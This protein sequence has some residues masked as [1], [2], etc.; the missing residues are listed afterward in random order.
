[1]Q[2][3]CRNRT[4]GPRRGRRINQQ[5]ERPAAGG[6]HG[7]RGHLA[8]DAGAAV[9]DQQSGGKEDERKIDDHGRAIAN[10]TTTRNAPH[11]R[12]RLQAGIAGGRSRGRDGQPIRQPMTSRARRSGSRSRIRQAAR[13]SRAAVITDTSNAGQPP[14][15]VAIPSRLADTVPLGTSRTV[16]AAGSTIGFMASMGKAA[17]TRSDNQVLATVISGSLPVDRLRARAAWAASNGA[18]RRKPAGRPRASTAN[19]IATRAPLPNN[20]TAVG[21]SGSRPPISASSRRRR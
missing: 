10:A 17:M 7:N 21:R 3:G 19:P 14:K 9:R 5:H 11:T 1:Q 13:P 12:N 18:A 15:P 16:A 6:Q 20:A 2:Q 8:P 4:D